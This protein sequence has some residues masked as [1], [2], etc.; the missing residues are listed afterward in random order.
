MDRLLA[1]R[2]AAGEQVVEDR[3]GA[4]GGGVE[5]VG[6]PVTNSMLTVAP[7]AASALCRGL[8]SGA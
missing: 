1:S 3:G 8:A 5:L 4:G 7:A 6:A 2:V